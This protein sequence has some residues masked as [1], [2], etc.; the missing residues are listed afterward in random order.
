MP[1]G[2]LRVR[3]YLA[4]P[5][6]SR[7]GEVLGGLFFGHSQPGIFTERAERILLG[8]AAQ[9]GVAI[10]NARLYQIGQR[11]VTARKEAEE[12]LQEL[13]RNL[14]RRAMQRADELASSA[15]KL[16]ESERGFRILV[17]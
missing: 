1:K 15:L 4:V 2:H 17:E 16:E 8:L 3:S 11:E 9:A 14:E 12:K 5:V 10:D 7:S 13:N 6:T